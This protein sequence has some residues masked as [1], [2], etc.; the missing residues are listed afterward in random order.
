MM[1]E[2]S[3]SSNRNSTI[4]GPDQVEEVVSAPERGT[5][6]GRFQED[7]LQ[8][9]DGFALRPNQAEDNLTAQSSLDQS[10]SVPPHLGTNSALV[11]PASSTTPGRSK[12][13]EATD[14]F[15]LQHDGQSQHVAEGS[16]RTEKTGEG[17]GLGGALNPEYPLQMGSLGSYVGDGFNSLLPEGFGLGTDPSRPGTAMTQNLA[18]GHRDVA[19]PQH[20]YAL[21]PQNTS[22]EENSISPVSPISFGFSGPH[23]A[24]HGQQ[25]PAGVPP[26]SV[27]GLDEQLPP[28]TRYPSTLPR[29]NTNEQGTSPTGVTGSPDDGVA[30]GESEIP[31]PSINNSESQIT[32]HSAFSDISQQR[33]ADLEK[34]ANL[35]KSRKIWVAT[36]KKRVC[37]GKLPLWGLLLCFVM[38]ILVVALAMGIIMGKSQHQEIKKLQAAQQTA[39]QPYEFIRSHCRLDTC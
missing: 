19:A 23:Q 2:L 7:P 4:L 34:P 28:Y 31:Q 3:S 20:P 15:A 27:L 12:A 39:G 25:S 10:Q 8:V 16:S 29:G 33:L 9:S 24:F 5:L 32:T 6:D 38:L 26:Q 14:S 35:S 13:D 21:Y 17:T 18:G 37:F 1:A 22:A 36:R 30:L 11:S